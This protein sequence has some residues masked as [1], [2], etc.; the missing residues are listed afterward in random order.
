MILRDSARQC[1]Y[2]AIGLVVFEYALRLDLSRF[3]LVLFRHLRL[4]RCCCSSA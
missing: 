3:F 1:A 4:G 2:G